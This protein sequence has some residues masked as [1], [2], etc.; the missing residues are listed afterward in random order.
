MHFPASA[1]ALVFLGKLQVTTLGK[2]QRMV[3]HLILRSVEAYIFFIIP[4]CLMAGFVLMLHLL[5]QQVCVQDVPF[6]FSYV[7]VAFIAHPDK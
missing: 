3:I 7:H 4:S 1:T 6:F 2:L 5:A